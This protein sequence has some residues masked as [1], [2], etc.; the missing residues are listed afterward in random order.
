MMKAL[1]TRIYFRVKSETKY[2]ETVRITGDSPMLGEWRHQDGVRLTTSEDQYPVWYTTE[3]LTLPSG[4]PV[5]YKYVIMEGPLLKRWEEIS[6]N[7]TLIPEGIEMT[8]EDVEGEYI[9]TST[10]KQLIDEKDEILD[11]SDHHHDHGPPDLPNMNQD[12]VEEPVKISPNETL[13]VCALEL[14]LKIRKRENGEWEIKSSQAVLLP[15]LYD[16]RERKNVRVVWI[17]HP[18]IQVDPADEHSLAQILYEDY[19]CIPVFIPV[20]VVTKHFQF[21]RGYLWPL[22][23]NIILV[24]GRRHKPQP[25]DNE[26]WQAYC[27]LNKIFA[28]KIVEFHHEGDMVW[29][30][31]FHLCLVPSYLTRRIRLANIGLFVHCP[32]PSS[33]IYRTLPVRDELLRGML[34]ADLIGF[35]LFEYARHFLTACKRLLGTNYECR[36]GGHLGVDYYGRHVMVRIGHV[37]IQPELIQ[38]HMETQ[39]VRDYAKELKERFPGKIILAGVDKLERLSGLHL[40]LLAFEN[41]LQNYPLYRHR[42]ILLQIGIPDLSR[43]DDY[44]LVKEDVDDIVLRINKEFGNVIHFWEE[45]LT[46]NKRLAVWSVADAIVITSIRDGLC[47]APFEYT[48]LRRDPPGAVVMSEFAGCSRALNGVLRVNPWNIEEVSS[49]MDRALTMPLQERTQRW[50]LDYHYVSMHSTLLWAENFLL[51]LK[52]ARKKEEQ[53][54]YMGLGFGLGYRVLG[55]GSDFLPLD[56]EEVSKSYRKSHNRVILLDHEG[57]LVPEGSSGATAAE[58]LSARGFGPSSTVL[59]CLEA[60]CKDEKNTVFI[61]SGREKKALEEWFGKIQGLGL[62]A[63]HGFFYRWSAAS[64][65]RWD[66]LGRHLDWSWKEVAN[67]ILEAY[68]QRTEGSFIERK[69]SALVWQYRD[70]DPDFGGWQ[71][72]ELTDH[73]EQVLM[74][75]PVIVI[76][77]KGYVEVKPRG[78]NKG[79][80]V[81]KI[82][83]KISATRGEVD[84]VLCIGDDRS[85]EDMFSALNSRIPKV[86]TGSSSSLHSLSSMQNVPIYTTTVGK[87][88]SHAHYFLNDMEEVLMVLEALRNQ[89]TKA[90]RTRSTN[91]MRALRREL[92]DST[93]SAILEDFESTPSGS[94]FGI[95]GSVHKFDDPAYAKSVAML[96]EDGSTRHGQYSG[97]HSD[98]STKH[99]RSRSGY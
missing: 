61:L 55:M 78:I 91:D 85:D 70:A 38:E 72:K 50:Q 15:T 73:L 1:F 29:I 89:S 8:V 45:D 53:F 90:S 86:G 6:G 3:P 87:K 2:G 79:V 16:L 48:A 35:H 39:E 62:A 4:I 75:F 27:A 49:A 58:H 56:P 68:T 51:D 57:T 77:G 95:K 19:Q 20:D 12:Y 64:G 30:H 31:D 74:N 21:C 81:E 52:R 44:E 94:G 32:F 11:I 26:L 24:Y 25:F 10:V 37:G 17:G 40:K 96:D 9:G 47:L 59:S 28:D 69:G 65:D 67:G 54:T 33:E 46:F 82:L 23:H 60:M 93:P 36:R 18:G 76:A 42:V 98:S 80:M 5:N 63:E 84:F 13:I 43:V 97:R 34:C 66:H 88:P 7:R 41:L 71:A 92:S 22:F 14:P 99:L 83:S